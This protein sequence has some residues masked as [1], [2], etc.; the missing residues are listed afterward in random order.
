[1]AHMLVLRFGVRMQEV[2]WV[3]DMRDWTSEDNRRVGRSMA[4]IIRMVQTGDAACDA[5]RR[6][7]PQLDNLFEIDGFEDFMVII[8]SSLLRDN[9]YGMIFRVSIRAA[10][11]TIDAATDIYVIATYY[12]SPALVGQANALLAMI[13]TN[14]V[15]QILSVLAQYQ[16]KSLAIKL[17]EVLISIFFLRPALDA[18]RVLTNHEDDEA[19]FDSLSEMIANKIIELGTESI[20]GCVLQLFV[21]Q[22][23]PE[24]AGTL[25]LASIGI[26]AMTTGFT[27]AIVLFDMDVGVL[28]RKNQPKFYGYIPDNNGRGEGVSC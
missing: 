10:L 28:H 25:A 15:V 8:A 23:N 18:Y 6:H 19:T 16:K 22:N 27:S 20:P 24:Q 13:T 9:K 7:Y 14:L 1:M 21:W 17:K 26:S 3:S 11:S 12:E 4:T 5:W 2:S